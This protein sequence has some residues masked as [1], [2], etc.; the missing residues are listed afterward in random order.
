MHTSTGRELGGVFPRMRVLLPFPVNNAKMAE[1]C[2]GP[3]LHQ[4]K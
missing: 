2:E 4:V 3:L 1:K